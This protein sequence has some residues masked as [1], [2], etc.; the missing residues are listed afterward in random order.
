MIPIEF[1][2]I[3]R[4]LVDLY[5]I[6]WALLVGHCSWSGAAPNKNRQSDSYSCILNKQYIMFIPNC[7]TCMYICYPIF[8][9]ISYNQEWLFKPRVFLV[10]IRFCRPEL[11][12][13]TFKQLIPKTVFKR[14]TRI[15]AATELPLI[16]DLLQMPKR[17]PYNIPK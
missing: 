17:H 14:K 3:K 12:R 8:I 6:T 9:L 15:Q 2:E 11:K 13:V 7:T 1:S 16:F 10:P 4:P 5:I